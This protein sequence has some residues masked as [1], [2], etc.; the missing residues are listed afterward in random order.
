MQVKILFFSRESVIIIK[1][2]LKFKSKWL[3]PKK[4]LAEAKPRFAEKVLG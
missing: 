1:N 4:Q 2:R 3:N